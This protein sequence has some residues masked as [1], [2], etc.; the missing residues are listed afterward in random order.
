[1]RSSQDLASR[2]LGANGGA[3]TP[4]FSHLIVSLETRAEQTF[5]RHILVHFRGTTWAACSWKWLFGSKHRS[6][7]VLYPAP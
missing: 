3:L 1:M 7:T 6:R 5:P 2:I 4:P